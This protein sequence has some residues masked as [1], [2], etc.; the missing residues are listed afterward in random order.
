MQY[1]RCCPLGWVVQRGR[2]LLDWLLLELDRDMVVLWGGVVPG[3]WKGGCIL[4]FK[5]VWFYE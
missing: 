4:E 2:G 3:S 1:Q 5:H